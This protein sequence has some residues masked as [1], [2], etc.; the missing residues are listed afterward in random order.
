MSAAVQAAAYIKA[1]YLARPSGAAVPTLHTA[2]YSKATTTRMHLVQALVAYEDT[3]GCHQLR[4]SSTAH[5][6]VGGLVA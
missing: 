5:E 3:M 2:A 4:S 6:I 1:T